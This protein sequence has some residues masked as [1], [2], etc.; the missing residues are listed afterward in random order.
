MRKEDGTRKDE[1]LPDIVVLINPVQEHIKFRKSVE[2]FEKEKS[3]TES[4]IEHER[5]VQIKGT[6]PD[7]DPALKEVIAPTSSEVLQEV[8]ESFN[9]K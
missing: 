3:D 2:T 4:S 8:A 5:F 1:A 9:C 7:Y 6:Y